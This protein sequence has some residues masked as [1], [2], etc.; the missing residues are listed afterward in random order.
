M[1]KKPA[2]YGWWIVAGCF[3]LTF[4]GI[5]ISINSIG[6]FL[7]P[8]TESLGFDRGRFPIFYYCC[9]FHGVGC[10]LYGQTA[11]QI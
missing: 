1:D 10:A 5:G 4:T 9:P 11:Q 7:K 8:V 6:V 2:F 3:L